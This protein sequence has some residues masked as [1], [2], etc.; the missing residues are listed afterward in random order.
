[1][2]LGDDGRLCG[3]NT[4]RFGRVW[5][6]GSMVVLPAT[7]GCSTRSVSLIFV[8]FFMRLD[9]GLE[10]FLKFWSQIWSLPNIFR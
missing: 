4:L 10:G 6:K 3:A 1:M 7:F 5:V 8:S 2:P 9:K